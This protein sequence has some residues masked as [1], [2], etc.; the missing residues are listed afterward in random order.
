LASARHG[1]QHGVIDSP[2]VEAW[3][4]ELVGHDIP[5]IPP[6]ADGTCGGDPA[7]ANEAAARG[8]WTCGGHVRDTDITSCPEKDTWGVSF[9]DGPSG[10][11]QYLLD[12][13]LEKDL[14]ATFFV[15][16][17]RVIER[18]ALLVEE[19][20]QGHEISVHTWSHSKPLTSLT[21]EQVVAELGWT[22]HAIKSVLGVTPTTMRPPWGDIDDRVRA[23]SL[24]MGMVPI[25][26]TRTPD[27]GVFDTNDW[28][29]A[30]GHA[31]GAESFKTFETI[32]KNATSDMETGFIV[33][34]HD[35]YEVAV[36][37]A[38][39]YTLPFALDYDP[40]LTLEPIGQCLGKPA[41]DMYLESNSNKTFP[42]PTEGGC[43]TKVGATSLLLQVMLA[44]LAAWAA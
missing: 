42:Y 30:G 12:F 16:G 33:L 39:G 37:L 17:S 29:V 41:R 21:T 43:A 18:P 1:E 27:N 20:M 4:E 11:T 9:D 6:T 22:R 10:Y 40:E 3:L 32:V 15:I 2:E 7:A 26:W 25:M 24:A 8:W 28:H 14:K 19:Y 34:Q 13:L 5:D 44:A 23:I 36:D 31:T 35:L 38:V